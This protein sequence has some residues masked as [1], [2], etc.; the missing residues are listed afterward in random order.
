MDSNEKSP[1]VLAGTTG[2]QEKN[3]EQAAFVSPGSETRKHSAPVLPTAPEPLP[4][5]S[6]F[7]LGPDGVYKVEINEGEDPIDIW[8]FSPLIV[9]GR[10]RDEYGRNWGLLLSVQTPEGKWHKWDMPAQMLGGNGTAFREML[11]ALGLRIAP[12]AQKHLYLYLATAKPDNVIR[13]VS[14]IGW[15]DGCFVL[16]D[17]VYKISPDTDIYF[18][19]IGSENL[20]RVKGTLTAW[21]NSIGKICALNS[22][23][24]L[25][26]CTAFA[27]PLLRLIGME[28]GGF[29][30]MG[31]SSLGKTTILLVAGS[32]C[33]GGGELGFL[34]RWRATDNAIEGIA[35]GH[36]DNLLCLDEIG[37]CDARVVAETSY[38]LANGQ[39]KSRSNKD[40]TARQTMEWRLLFLSTGELSIAQKLAEDGRRFMAG[41]AVRI[42]DI[43]ADAGAGSGV[44]E[45]LY[46]FSSGKQLSEHLQR[47]CSLNYGT[48]LRAYLE[49]LTANPHAAFEHV[50]RVQ[51]AL[52]KKLCPPKADGQVQRVAR[53]FAL[54]AAA[55]EL[56]TS[57][58]ILPWPELA[59]T[60]CIERCF[61][62]WLAH[63]GGGDAAE[64]REAIERVR[65]FV[66]RHG[67]SRFINLGNTGL[68]NV[69]NCAGFRKAE[70]DECLYLV[71]TSVFRSEICAGLDHNT[72]AK[73]LLQAG[74]LEAR[75]DNRFYKN[76]SITGVGKNITLYTIRASILGDTPDTRPVPLSH[77]QNLTD[78]QL[79]KERKTG[80][81]DL[82]L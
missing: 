53:R 28:G 75:N 9:E 79:Q 32:V 8:A 42:V 72:V 63:H 61:H 59:A 45:Q 65:S 38:M 16:P 33:G 6:S 52:E 78:T 22:Q 21:Q 34:R 76:Y 60:Y 82:V 25:A 55:G 36:N 48:P 74:Y 46:D 66:A 15:Q 20:F 54:V 13:R 10:T 30:F 67:S 81:H 35:Q 37:Q 40:G 50:M 80:N 62:R 2:E 3:S 77:D 23:L 58:G 26:I 47:A 68:Q 64:M 71:Y 18:E 43:P 31:N 57:Y 49:K 70:N 19:S 14:S 7:K 5:S 69:P 17:V 73:Y 12:G 4:W 44:Y 1:E 27:A 24:T 41:Q 56:A 39:G 11:L 29:H 51:A